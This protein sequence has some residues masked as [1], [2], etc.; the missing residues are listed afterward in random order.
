MELQFKNIASNVI[1]FSPFFFFYGIYIFKAK[2]EEKFEIP[3]FEFFALRKISKI[4][5]FKYFIIKLN[6]TF[7]DLFLDI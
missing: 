3:D 7:I 5:N 1:S 4:L 2:I 6:Y